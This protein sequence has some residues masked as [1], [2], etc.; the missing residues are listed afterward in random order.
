MEPDSEAER[1]V[2]QQIDKVM[3]T[4]PARFSQLLQRTTQT[5]WS[6]ERGPPRKTLAD[7]QQDAAQIQKA[8]ADLALQD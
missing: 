8:F 7:R 6:E 5:N 1:A 2:Q 4:A 3:S